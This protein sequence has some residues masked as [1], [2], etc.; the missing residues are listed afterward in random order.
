M[1]KYFVDSITEIAE[2]SGEGDLLIGNEH[3]GSVF[4]QFDMRARP[5]KHGGEI[6]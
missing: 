4:E 2:G 3:P 6:D 5:E 1:R